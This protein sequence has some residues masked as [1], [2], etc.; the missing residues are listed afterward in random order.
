MENIYSTQTNGLK[1]R[2]SDAK[3]YTSNP[4]PT[5]FSTFAPKPLRAWSVNQRVPLE[6]STGSMDDY[7]ENHDQ[8]NLAR[9]DS[10]CCKQLTT[11]C[12]EFS[13]VVD[14]EGVALFDEIETHAAGRNRFFA[15]FFR[16]N[17]PEENSDADNSR[18]AHH[19]DVSTEESNH[20][21][22]SHHSINGSSLGDEHENHSFDH[23]SCCNESIQS[24]ENSVDEVND[25][26]VSISDTSTTSSG[27]S[28]RAPPKSAFCDWKFKGQGCK[29]N[30]NRIDASTDIHEILQDLDSVLEVCS[31]ENGHSVLR[32]MVNDLLVELH[33]LNCEMENAV[34]KVDRI[35]AL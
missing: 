28:K 26:S 23:H 1:E 16:R 11:K 12:V 8:V 7:K 10:S 5:R 21:M 14:L 31:M 15:G 9:V 33:R 4:R 34:K 20:C 22:G 30:G 19:Y 27:S 35:E 2:N 18:C 24:V 6:V 32:Q 29:V 17:H 25:S 3:E 13:D